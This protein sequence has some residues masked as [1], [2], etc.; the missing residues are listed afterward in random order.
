MKGDKAKLE[1]RAE[2]R[3]ELNTPIRIDATICRPRSQSAKMLNEVDP[4]KTRPYLGQDFYKIRDECF[5]SGKL[6]ED[7]YFRCESSST[8]IKHM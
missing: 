5:K 4:T 1:E 2:G 8:Q 7:P 6:F 3:R